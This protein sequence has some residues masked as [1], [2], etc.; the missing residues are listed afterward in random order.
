MQA[1][2]IIITD[3]DRVRKYLR[4]VHFDKQ[5]QCVTQTI[6]SKWGSQEYSHERCIIG[7]TLDIIVI[8]LVTR[9]VWTNICYDIFF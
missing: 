7:F 2:Y 4:Y 1:L 8:C 3:V 6:T 9:L 5:S